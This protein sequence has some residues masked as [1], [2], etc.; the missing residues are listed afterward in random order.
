MK[1]RNKSDQDLIVAGQMTKGG[2]VFESTV[3]IEG[4]PNFEE[5]VEEPAAAPAAAPAAPQAPQQ[6]QGGL[7]Q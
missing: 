4:N 3:P 5:V 6:P 1:Y 7:S 2:S